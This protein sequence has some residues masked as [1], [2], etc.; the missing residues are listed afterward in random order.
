VNGSAALRANTGRLED[1]ASKSQQLRPQLLRELSA[2]RLMRNAIDLIRQGP[3][4]GDLRP[5]LRDARPS[6][7]SRVLTDLRLFRDSVVTHA[8][9]LGAR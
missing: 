1:L 5:D 8:V 7:A 9:S 6:S 4:D 3:H 2:T